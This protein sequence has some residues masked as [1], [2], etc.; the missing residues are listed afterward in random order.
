MRDKFNNEI[1]IGDLVV[2][3]CST[4]LRLGVV[5]KIVPGWGRSQINND[6]R[7]LVHVK[8]LAEDWDPAIPWQ[9]R[10]ELSRSEDD[11]MGRIYTEKLVR[12]QE[13]FRL[14]KVDMS[15]IANMRPRQHL[16]LLLN[17]QQKIK[18]KHLKK[19]NDS[20]I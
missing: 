7:D 11:V 3:T 8:Y 18:T 12:N 13:R 20:A 16:E 17:I 6:S 4:A 2:T 15:Q 9:T 1:Q 10:V 5:T 19:R 14:I